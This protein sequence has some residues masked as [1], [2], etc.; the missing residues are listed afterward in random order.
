MAQPVPLVTQ[1]GVTNTVVMDNVAS[2]AARQ[3]RVRP[4]HQAI[5]MVATKDK[6]LCGGKRL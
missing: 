4:V 6:L 5:Q 2:I 3:V 1:M